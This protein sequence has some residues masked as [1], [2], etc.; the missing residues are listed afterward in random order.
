MPTLNEA[1]Q[2]ASRKQ[3]VTS[4]ARERRSSASNAARP[5]A[6]PV[7]LGIS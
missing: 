1:K 3:A 4:P 2:R 6:I 7:R 5:V